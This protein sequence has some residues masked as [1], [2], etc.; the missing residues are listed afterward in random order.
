M[1]NQHKLSIIKK[2]T[3]RNYSNKKIK[4]IIK[5]IT[6]ISTNQSYKFKKTTNHKQ[7]PNKL[8]LFL[9]NLHQMSIP[10]SNKNQHFHHLQVIKTL[11]NQSIGTMSTTSSLQTWTKK[12]NSCL[13]VY[14]NSSS[15]NQH[16]TSNGYKAS[17]VTLNHSKCHK[18]YHQ[19]SV[20]FLMKSSS[21]QL[22]S[23]NKTTNSNWLQWMRS[24]NEISKSNHITKIPINSNCSMISIKVLCNRIKYH[25]KKMTTIG[26]NTQ[27]SVD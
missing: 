5:I 8:F 2:I 6:K 9:S 20:N 24:L 4:R 25:K 11:V 13:K 22:K 1:K 19:E 12:P 26:I 17:S 15:N 18:K 14:C 10:V 27:I 7:N 16:T 23:N 3:I 21:Q